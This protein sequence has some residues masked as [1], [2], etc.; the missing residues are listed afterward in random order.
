MCYDY[1]IV[2]HIPSFYKVNLYNELS[3]KLKIFVVFVA[4]DTV[5]RRASDFSTLQNINFPYTVLSDEF[6][7]KR[8][9][10]SNIRKLRA[11]LTNNCYKRL[12]VNG[13][14]LKEFWYLIMLSPKSKNCLALESTIIDSKTNGIKGLMKKIFL[15]RISLVFASGSL[16]LKLLHALNFRG[17]IKITKGVGII[18]K[19]NYI[20]TDKKYRRKF[21]YIG[22]LTKV[23]NLE[24]IVKVFNNLPNHTLTIIGD[25]EE[26]EYLRSIAKHNIIFKPPIENSK[27]QFELPNYD[28]LILPSIREAW[29]LVV[30]EALY[31]GLPVMVSKNCGSIDLVKNSI[32][33]YIFDPLNEEEIR[34]LILNIDDAIYENLVKGVRKFS[35]HEKDLHQI[36]SYCFD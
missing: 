12:L 6:L 30:E 28:I 27:L 11:I 21:V 18:N 19:P 10:K 29:G 15:S 23:K 20:I 2:T 32:N 33:G 25:G 8:D 14:D 1:I 26:K 22:R 9:I 17:T 36:K 16:H 35:I 24:I 34:T 13:W 31:F 3:R 4:I 7:Q 5:E